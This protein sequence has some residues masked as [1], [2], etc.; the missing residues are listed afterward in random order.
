MV[1]EE[2]HNPKM[3]DDSKKRTEEEEE[4][5]VA[6]TLEFVFLR[7]PDKVPLNYEYE[8][9]KDRLF[10]KDG[11]PML[12]GGLAIHVH[13]WFE[14]LRKKMDCLRAFIN[15]NKGRSFADM[16]DLDKRPDFTDTIDQFM[17]GSLLETMRDLLAKIMRAVLG[18][19]C[20]YEV[21]NM[22]ERLAK[23]LTGVDGSGNKYDK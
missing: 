6:T 12:Y 19:R 5:P 9:M 14:D 11:K 16:I 3:S 7:V 22:D 15:Q 10:D 4:V 21:Q 17:Y 13:E 8:W 18:P 2:L 20:K 23:F 1:S